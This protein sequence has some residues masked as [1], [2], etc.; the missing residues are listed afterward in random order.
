MDSLHVHIVDMSDLESVRRFA[1]TA[2]DSIGAVDGL[3]NN[4]G[5]MREKREITNQGHD[6]NFATNLLGPALLTELMLPHLAKAEPKG[7]VVMVSS[8]GM[9]TECLDASDPQLK[10]WS[11]YDGTRAYAQNKRAQVYLTAYWAKA[12]GDGAASIDDYRG[13]GFFS[14]H[15]GWVDTPAVRTSMPDFHK[16]MDGRL[17]DEVGGADTVIWLAA[18]RLGPN[19]RVCGGVGLNGRFF[20]DRQPAVTHLTGCFTRSS[21]KDIEKLWC[22]VRTWLDLPSEPVRGAAGFAHAMP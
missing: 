19:A 20:F 13:I 15:P 21:I 3:V 14:C 18:G 2:R 11:S 9:L 12:Y 5:V 1:E 16:R 10:D 4:A 22:Q 6:Y 17:R 8:G 7:T